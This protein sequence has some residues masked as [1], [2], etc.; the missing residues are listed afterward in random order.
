MASRRKVFE[1]SGKVIGLK[2][3]KK[4]AGGTPVNF[5]FHVTDTGIS[6][7]DEGSGI[8]TWH[9]DDPVYASYQ[10]SLTIDGDKFEW[11]SVEMGKKDGNVIKGLEVVIFPHS[12]K[13]KGWM[14]NPFIMET[15][16]NVSNEEFKNTA[17]ESP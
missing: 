17:Y 4:G 10:G 15:E 1:E 2:A 8:I 13:L 7:E 12:P 16:M 6:G 5:K 3:L 9:A 11:E 14:K